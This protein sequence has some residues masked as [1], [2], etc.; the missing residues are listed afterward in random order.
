MFQRKRGRRRLFARAHAA[1]VRH[2]PFRPGEDVEDVGDVDAEAVSCACVCCGDRAVRA[3]TDARG[4][5]GSCAW[6]LQLDSRHGRCRTRLRLLSRCLRHRA[7]AIALRAE[8]RPPTRRR[9]RSGPPSQAGSDPLVW[10]LTNTHGSRFRTVF[11]RAPNTPFGLELSEFF[12]IARGDRAANPWD[13]GAS[14]THLLGPRSRR[15]RRQTEGPRRARRDARR[16][17]ARH[18]GAAARCSSAIPTAT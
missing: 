3:R 1:A 9:R 4:A 5:N 16:R 15:R 14:A 6:H 18:A 11:M 10:D 17:P 12:D 8:P 2:W 7:R 13:P